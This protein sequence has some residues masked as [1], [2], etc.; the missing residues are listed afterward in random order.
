MRTLFFVLS[1][2]LAVTF[3]DAGGPIMTCDWPPWR[4]PKRVGICTETSLHKEWPKGGPKLLWDSKKVNKDPSVGI[5]LSSLAIADG[6]IYTMGDLL[7]V[8]QVEFKN[9]EGKIAKKNVTKGGN[10][11]LFCLD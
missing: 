11:F 7:K 6:K 8:E 4:G 2:A 10:V 3:C 1:F 5:G 9:K